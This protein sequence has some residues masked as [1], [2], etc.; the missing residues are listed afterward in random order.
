MSKVQ[1]NYF[2]GEQANQ[3]NF[4]RIPKELVVGE[5][6]SSLCVQSKVLYGILLDR[7]GMSGKNKW[8]D[9]EDRVYII[10]SVEDIQADMGISKHKVVECLAELESA[11]LILKRKRGKGLPNQIYVKNFIKTQ[12]M[13]LA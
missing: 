10:Y 4:I 9:E 1:M 3:F 11:G 13:A 12:S 7:M 6:A 8:V 2:Y 5:E